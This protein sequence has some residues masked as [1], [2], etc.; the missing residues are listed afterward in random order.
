MTRP[1]QPRRNESLQSGLRVKI[2]LFRSTRRQSRNK[3]EL[4]S[5]TAPE[6]DNPSMT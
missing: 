6:T 1:K 4:E 2:D 3:L 5:G